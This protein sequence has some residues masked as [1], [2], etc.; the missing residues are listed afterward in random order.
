MSQKVKSRKR[1]IKKEPKEFKEVVL[2]ID[3][4]TR[5]TKGGRQL[6]F[7]ATVA[8]G[9]KKGKV[10]I[11]I[12]KSN[13]V[14]TAIQKAI[15]KAKKGLI[16]VNTDKTSIPH[17]I[18]VKFKASRILLLPA[19]EGT[20]VKAG[21]AVRQI[22]ELA[23]I[24]D[25]LSKSYGSNNKLNTAQ[26]TIKGLQMLK[27]VE[28]QEEEKQEKKAPKAKKPAPKKKVVKK[29]EK[30]KAEKQEATKESKEKKTS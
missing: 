25:I 10:G 29:E 14:A 7:R 12:G 27:K 28:G 20:G 13:E 16:T 23:G 17:Q 21:G 5:V 30:P 15:Q 6:R 24:K 3:R 9:N 19:S 18:K 4:V 1:R 11:G 22:I 26:A 8:I 2:Q